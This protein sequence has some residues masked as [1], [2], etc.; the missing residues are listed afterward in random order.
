MNEFSYYNPVKVNFG[1]NIVEKKIQTITK[2]K[3]ILILTSSSFS[4]SGVIKNLI[5]DFKCESVKIIDNITSHPEILFLEK[6]YQ[7]VRQDNYDFI[8]ALGGGS[9]ID[10]A[11][12]VSV[13][14]DQNNFSFIKDILIRQKKPENYQIIPLIAIPTTAG[15]GSEV[16]PWATVWDQTNLIKYSFELPDLWPKI[17][18]CDPSLTLSLP[19]DLTIQTALDALSHSFEAIWNVNNNP[20]STQ[21]AIKSAQNIISFLPLLI[22]DLNSLKLREKILFS[23]LQAGLAFSNTKTSIAHAISYYLTLEKNIPHGL[24][25]SITLPIILEIVLEEQPNLKVIF[26]EILGLEPTSILK[27]FFIKISVSTDLKDYNINLADLIKIKDSLMKTVRIQNSLIDPELLFKR[28][29]I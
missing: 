2:E 26:E 9:V 8:I 13:F 29:K 21:Y 1:N 27:D 6:V 14:N 28:I 18:I 23:S 3:K 7:E 19:R 5:K 15:T 10:T 12:V 16:T 22:D 24:A 20:I 25:C 4:K 17:C 11:K